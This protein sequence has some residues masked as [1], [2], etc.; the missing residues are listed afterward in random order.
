MHDRV[1][2][3]KLCKCDV[4]IGYEEEDGICVCKRD[5]GCNSPRGG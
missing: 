4:N 2:N 3:V 1:G 5:K